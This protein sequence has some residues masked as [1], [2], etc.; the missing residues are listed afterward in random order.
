MALYKFD[1][2]YDHYYYYY[3]KV[4]QRSLVKSP[5]QRTPGWV[6]SQNFLP[7]CNKLVINIYRAMSKLSSVTAAADADADVEVFVVEC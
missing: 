1:C 5:D 6:I 2:Y 7:G 4:Q 3:C